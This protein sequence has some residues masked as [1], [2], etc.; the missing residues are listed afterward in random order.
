MV[1]VHCKSKTVRHLFPSVLSDAVGTVSEHIQYQNT[2]CLGRA[3]LRCFPSSLSTYPSR[4]NQAKQ[5]VLSLLYKLKVPVAIAQAASANLCGSNQSCCESLQRDAGRNPDH[6]PQIPDPGQLVPSQLP[7]FSNP[8]HCLPQNLPSRELDPVAA[9]CCLFPLRY[10]PH[11]PDLRLRCSPKS[12][13]VY[14]Q[15]TQANLALY[16]QTR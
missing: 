8:G 5:T 4:Y 10:P 7:P 2:N 9:P 16:L 12:P 6:R 3:R 14:L 15:P 1:Y 13:S 11:P